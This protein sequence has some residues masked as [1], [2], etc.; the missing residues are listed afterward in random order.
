MKSEKLRDHIRSHISKVVTPDTKPKDLLKLVKN[1]YPDA[2]SKDIALAAFSAMI[3]MADEDVD[4]ARALQSLGL[5][6]RG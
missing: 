5:D 1:K 6:R 4:K 2:S 3:D